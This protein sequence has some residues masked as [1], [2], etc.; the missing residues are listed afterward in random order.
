MQY[1]P[2]YLP[3]FLPTYLPTYYADKSVT[4]LPFTKS[5]RS[6]RLHRAFFVVFPLSP[7]AAGSPS[8]LSFLGWRFFAQGIPWSS[9]FCFLSA[10]H[11]SRAIGV[12]ADLDACIFPIAK[13]S[14]RG[15]GTEGFLFFFVFFLVVLVGLQLCCSWMFEYL[16]LLACLFRNRF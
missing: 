4:R 6:S 1:L 10:H 15:P 11:Y 13:K 14:Q 12:C 9:R 16:S 5:H 7:S 2:T 3:T 8:G